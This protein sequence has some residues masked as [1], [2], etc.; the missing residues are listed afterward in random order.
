MPTVN[1]SMSNSTRR[2]RA[3]G[4]EGGTDMKTPPPVNVSDETDCLEAALN[5]IQKQGDEFAL[6]VDQEELIRAWNAGEAVDGLRNAQL[7]QSA[8][9]LFHPDVELNRALY[10]KRVIAGNYHDFDLDEHGLPYLIDDLLLLTRNVRTALE[11]VKQ[12][13]STRTR[14]ILSIGEGTG[15]L[16]VPMIEIAAQLGMKELHVIDLLASHISKVR[17]KIE[18][19]YETTEEA[20]NVLS[21]DNGLT[22]VLQAGDFMR[23]GPE[24]Q[25]QYDLI[26]SWWFM[27]SEIGDFASDEDHR[28]SRHSFYATVRNLLSKQGRYIEDVPFSEGTGFYY[29]ARIKTGIILTAL[30]ILP[31]ENFNMFLS[32]FSGSQLLG[33]DTYPHH[34]RATPVNGEQRREMDDAGFTEETHTVTTLAR[35]IRHDTYKDLRR[36]FGNIANLRRLFA[37]NDL[38]D[39]FRLLEDAKRK[40]VVTAREGRAATQRK[41]TTIWKPSNQRGTPSDPIIDAVEAEIPER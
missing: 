36:N 2:L 41:K 25:K 20:E 11:S 14:H 17:G 13:T 21:L 29:L 12:A 22:V 37:S 33:T 26:V 23:I 6:D 32:N 27:S 8:Q 35:A 4:D 38:D 16:T 28:G 5:A 1:Y 3:S 15:R 24:L 19:V 34:V 30:G 39:L 7:I 31:R 40:C 18:A 10:V 9:A